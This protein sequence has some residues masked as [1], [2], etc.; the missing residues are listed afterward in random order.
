MNEEL[1][2]M[3]E[4]AQNADQLAYEI[5]FIKRQA[6]ETLLS[7]SVQIGARLSNA[8]ELVP[9]GQ[10]SAWLKEK[11]DYS[12]STADNLMRIYRE[13]GD[14]QIGLSGKSKSQI[15]ANLT[16]SQAIALFALPEHQREEFVEQ[17]D[18]SDMTTKELKE[19]IAAQKAAEQAKVQAETELEKA[20]GEI[21]DMSKA[22][23]LLSQERDDARAESEKY[24]K[25][26]NS[27]TDSNIQQNKN[28]ERIS[29]M[30]DKAE[31]EAEKAKAEAKRLQQELDAAN[32]K[33]QELTAAP[34]EISEE[35]REAIRA[36]IEEKYADKLS[37]LTLDAEITRQQAEQMAA[38]K[39]ALEAKAAQMAN[40]ELIR[41]NILFNQSQKTLQEMKKILESCDSDQRSK[42][43]KLILD[44]TQR[45]IGKETA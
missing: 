44:T 30:R 41:L 11:V 39:A 34:A 6:L 36:E 33:M 19:A 2:P 45:I 21:N 40:E 43:T 3:Q 17:H 24:R 13:Y 14:E 32:A 28:A 29:K 25:L 31:K 16:Y 7:S 26:Y 15:F 18:V 23:D 37:Q 4:E 5:N 20:Q 1:K 27:A 42:L 38:E 10:W 35:D 8:K 12:Q 22:C 9:H